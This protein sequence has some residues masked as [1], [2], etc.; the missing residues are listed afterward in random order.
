MKTQHWI[1]VAASVVL[2]AVVVRALFPKTETRTLTLPGSTDTVEVTRTDLDTLWRERVEW[3]EV[4]TT[5]TVVLA[6]T[7]FQTAVETVTVL[8]GR[9]Y[10]D[11]ARLAQSFGDTSYYALTWLEADSADRNGIRRRN[12]IE[13]HVTLGPVRQIA[14]DSSG[15]SVDYGEFPGPGCGFGCKLQWGLGGA[16]VGVLTY[17]I[18][19]P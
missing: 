10:L 15:L 16:S 5:D 9:W 6:D 18:F 11:S 17:I 3:R 7:V 13:R 14:T 12:A 4:A 2:T 8:P 19:G 1:I